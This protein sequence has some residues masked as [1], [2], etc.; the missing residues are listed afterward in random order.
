MAKNKFSLDFGGF[1]DYAR[2][3]DERLGTKALQEAATEALE[4]SAMQANMNISLAMAK[5]PY[6][7]KSGQHYSKG[8]AKKSLA[9]TAKKGVEVDGTLITAFAGVDLSEAPEV[10]ILAKG[11]PH[12]KADTNLRNAVKCKGKYR[13]EIMNIQQRIFFE[14]VQSVA[15]K[16]ETLG[17]M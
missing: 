9:E 7:F 11:S 2:I 1:L 14:K 6:S 5:S 8:K 10:A 15:K 16:G 12:L 4:K 13:K 17:D 3:I